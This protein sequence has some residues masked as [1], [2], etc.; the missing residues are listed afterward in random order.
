M[1]FREKFWYLFPGAVFQFFLQERKEKRAYLSSLSSEERREI[2]KKKWR[3]GIA[4]FISSIVHG[5]LFFAVFYRLINPI[6]L[7]EATI[8]AKETLD[9]DIMDGMVSSHLDPVYDEMSEFI[10]KPSALIKNEDRKKVDLSNLL[11]QLKTSTGPALSN[12]VVGKDREYKSRLGQEEESLKAGLKKRSRPKPRIT[13]INKPSRSQLWDR[14][15]LLKTTQRQKGG[16]VNYGDIMKVIDKHSF[17]F[18]ECYEKALLRDESLSGKVTFLLKLNRNKV[19]KTGLEL[20]GKGNT[21]SRRAL[22]RCLFQASKSLSFPK[23]TQK[24]SVKF[25]LIFGL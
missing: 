7:G 18:Q 13:R 17:Q 22:T 9:F 5:L 19:K 10:I 11:D 16:P 14:M 21:K 2:R 1:P 24:V 20:K 12:K 25:N 6:L 4:F 8:I 3:F 15:K 23:N